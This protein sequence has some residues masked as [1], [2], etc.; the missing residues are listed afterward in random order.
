M[1]KKRKKVRKVERSCRTF[2]LSKAGRLRGNR[3][4]R[5]KSEFL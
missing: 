2:A 3:V 1:L 4:D 5:V